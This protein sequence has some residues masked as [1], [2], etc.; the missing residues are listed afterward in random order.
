MTTTTK[1]PHLQSIYASVQREQDEDEKNQL[2]HSPHDNDNIED[3]FATIDTSTPPKS[4]DA[5][6]YHRTNTQAPF[7]DSASSTE[8]DHDEDVCKNS[9]SKIIETKDTTAHEPFH[10]SVSSEEHDKDGENNDQDNDDKDG[11]N[12]D[13]DN[14][15]Q[16]TQTDLY[17]DP[18]EDCSTKD[19]PPLSP[20]P[21]PPPRSPTS[22][23]TTTQKSPSE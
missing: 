20:P 19:A 22:D 23:D 12:N 17:N 21:P 11:E 14:D 7:H 8:E 4:E 1:Y 18:N 9:D 13:Q 6:D 15:D 5:H 10:D 2:L 16:T 3:D